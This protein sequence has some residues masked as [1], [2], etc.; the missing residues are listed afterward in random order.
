MDPSSTYLDSRIGEEV[1]TFKRG[2]ESVSANQGDKLASE[3]PLHLRHAV[4]LADEV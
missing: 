4:H 3:K 1:L 2:M